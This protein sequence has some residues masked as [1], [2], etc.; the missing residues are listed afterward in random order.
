MASFLFF[1]GRFLLHLFKREPR[2]LPSAAL[3]FHSPEDFHHVYSERTIMDFF[4]QWSFIFIPNGYCV[5]LKRTF[6]G[7]TL[8]GFSFILNPQ[9]FCPPKDPLFYFCDAWMCG[10]M[11]DTYKW[12]RL[13]AFDL[14]CLRATKSKEGYCRHP[15]LYR[16]ILMVLGLNDDN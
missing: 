8:S 4:P 7:F 5:S 16:L 15:N 9:Q 6:T 2:I 1:P 10:L 12:F 13:L 14:R 3:Y 11:S